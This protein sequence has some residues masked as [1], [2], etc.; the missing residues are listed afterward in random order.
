MHVNVP[1]TRT[2]GRSA[3]AT[4]EAAMRIV[5]REKHES[6]F[7]MLI[8]LMKL[9]IL[10]CENVRMMTCTQ[11]CLLA[12]P[13][14]ADFPK[15]SLHCTELACWPHQGVSSVNDFSESIKTPFFFFLLTGLPHLTPSSPD[16]LPAQDNCK[17]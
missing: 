3:E 17:R 16:G 5:E 10:T 2:I 11:S 12:N 6:N 13:L 15:G 9:L 14:L 8:Y 1:A 4:Y 7:F